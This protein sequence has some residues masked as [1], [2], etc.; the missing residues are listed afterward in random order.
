MDILKIMEDSKKL[1][2]KAISELP[3]EK[4]EEMKDLYEK[5][6]TD[7]TIAINEVNKLINGN[8]TDK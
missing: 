2:N 3:K 4:Q 1:I 5:S 8:N 7:Y 6:L